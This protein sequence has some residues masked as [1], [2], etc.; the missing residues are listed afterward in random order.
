LSLEFPYSLPDSVGPVIIKGGSGTKEDIL[1]G[2]IGNSVDYCPTTQIKYMFQSILF[3]NESWN[4]FGSVTD[5]G[6]KSIEWNNRYFY[7]L[8][9]P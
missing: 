7:T 1:V 9:A 4:I 8:Y 6:L 3:S 2:I 5:I